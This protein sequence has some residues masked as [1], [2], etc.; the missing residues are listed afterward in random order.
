MASGLCRA[1]ALAAAALLAVASARPE[2]RAA[3]HSNGPIGVNVFVMGLAYT[4][5]GIAE[6]PTHSINDSR[7]HPRQ[8]GAR[9]RG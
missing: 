2:H 3:R 7:T 1:A 9:L 6:N 5:G 8:R 4:Q